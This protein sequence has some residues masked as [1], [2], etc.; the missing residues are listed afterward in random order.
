MMI[1]TLCND[2][3][4]E[5]KL[6]KFQR[7]GEPTEAALKVMAEKLG[8]SLLPS[9]LSQHSL[10]SDLTLDKS[11]LASKYSDYYNS[12]FN[13]LALLEF[14][15]DRKSMSVLIDKSGIDVES[16]KTVKKSAS[17][18]LLVKG[19][20]EMVIRRC[21]RVKLHNG[22][23][24]PLSVEAKNEITNSLNSLASRSLR[25]LALAYKEGIE[26]IG[27]ELSSI[28]ANDDI[29]SLSYLKDSSKFVEYEKDMVLVGCCGIKDPARPEAALAIQKCR[30]A[31]IRVMMITGDSKD[32][33]VRIRNILI[34]YHY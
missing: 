17:K 32:T 18:R 14:N 33:A 5:Y 7:V 26:E 9:E 12:K 6:G 4:I 21:N 30:Q 3:S 13:R 31:G 23:I 27:P 2:A 25:C 28:T 1:S 34:Q 10:I 15:R 11:Q 22:I 24:I 8:N 20:A 16:N 19:A 29:S